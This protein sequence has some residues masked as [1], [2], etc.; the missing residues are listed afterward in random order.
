L[1][2]ATISDSTHQAFVDESS[3]V[4]KGRILLLSACIHTY[5]EWAAFSE[6]WLAALHEPPAI[7]GFHVR[8]ARQRTGEFAGWKAIDVDRKIIALTEVVLR[9]DPHVLTVWT[10]EDDYIA[11]V[12]ANGVPD[13]RHAYFACF[14]AILIKVAE[15]QAWQKIKTPVDFIFDEKGNIGLEA[16][17]WYPFIKE[18]AKPEF[19]KLLG[20]TP[21]FRNDKDMLPLQAADLITW[22]KRR[23]KEFGKFD[24]EVAASMRIDELQGGEA[25]IDRANLEIMASRMALLPGIKESQSQPSIYK[26]LKR[27]MRKA[28]RRAAAAKT[29]IEFESF[30]NAMDTILR[31]NPKAV[32]E[33]IEAEKQH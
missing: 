4:G 25:H 9:H 17:H 28:M 27:D 6:D 10:S 16:L 15:Y 32:K 7:T 29:N 20:S 26:Q 3:G 22:H 8:E 24:Q 21:I 12:R 31:A 23:Q 30:D 14:M 13:V 11:T 18:T 1:E 2:S 5:L 19:Q 33:A